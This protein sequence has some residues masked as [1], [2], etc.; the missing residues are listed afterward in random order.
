MLEKA[1]EVTREKH[2]THIE[3]ARFADDIVVLID[4]HS[5]W[6]WLVSA[7]N[8]RLQGEFTKLGVEI[9]QDK[10][11][12]V[13]LEKGE[14]FSFLGFDFHKRK[15]WKGK[16]IVSYNPKSKA[17][18]TLMQKIKET[19][20]KNRSQPVS[21]VIEK[22]NPIIRGWTNYFR[23][24]H[25]SRCFGYIRDW[26][27]RKVRRHMMRN[28]KRRGFGWKRWSSEWIYGNLGLFDD[29]KIR[30]IN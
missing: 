20:K 18:T 21:R 23:I 12:I 26:I 2:Y 30:Y 13:N 16:W 3:Y 28:R 15:N 1:K 7:V 25:S 11:K 27:E 5:K 29:Y 6:N 10:T 24:G 4:E 8:K 22:I 19:F 14:N 17:K 9:N